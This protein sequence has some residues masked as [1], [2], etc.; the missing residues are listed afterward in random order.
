[1]S[2]AEYQTLAE[3]ASRCGYRLGVL[4]EAIAEQFFDKGKDTL[5]IARMFYL[6]EGVVY[7]AIHSWREAGR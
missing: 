6:T 2:M 7:N 3:V 5:D 1:M 4:T